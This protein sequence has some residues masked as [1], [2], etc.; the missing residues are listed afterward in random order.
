M[1]HFY[2]LVRAGVSLYVWLYGTL[3][4]DDLYMVGLL[5]DMLSFS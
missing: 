4:V 3:Q 5:Y 1:V 2:V